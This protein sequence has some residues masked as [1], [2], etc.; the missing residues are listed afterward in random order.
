MHN[1][2]VRR[3][4]LL[5][6]TVLAVAVVVFFMID[7]VPGDPVIVML[8]KDASEDTVAAVRHELGLDRPVGERMLNWFANLAKGDL[9][10]SVFLHQPVTTA[11]AERYPVT[12]S[13]AVLS[14]IVALVVGIS[15]G[16]IAA[17]Y[18]GRLADWAAMLIAVVVMSLPIFWLALNLIYFFGVRLRW[19]PV[20]GFVSF[21]E[22][23]KEFVLHLF[24]PCVSL[25]LFHAAIIAR[26]TRTCMLEVLSMD[27]VRTARAKGLRQR[28]VIVRHALR[29]ALIPIVTVVGMS[30]GWMLEGSVVTETV[31]N[32]PGVGRLVVDAVRRRDYFV[33]QGSILAVT[34]VYMAINLLVDVLY[35]YVDPRIRYD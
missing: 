7:L 14:L 24:L 23:P 8:G 29:N 6:P 13:M 4:M 12:L 33:V 28:I 21:S 27:Y 20:G 22:S 34:V 15:A 30:V 32:L 19:L 5:I 17:L 1:Y 31:Y 16:I 2:L 35:T 11:L 26:T 10:D 9:G 18:Q 3:V 25:G